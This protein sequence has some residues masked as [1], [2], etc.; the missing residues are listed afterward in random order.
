MICFSCAL[1]FLFSTAVHFLSAVSF[2]QLIARCKL[3]CA[4]ELKT[5]S[6]FYQDLHLIYWAITRLELLQAFFLSLANI[7]N[8]SILFVPFFLC[9]RKLVL[10]Q[11][12]QT[13]LLRQLMGSRWIYGRMMSSQIFSPDQCKLSTLSFLFQEMQPETIQVTVFSKQVVLFSSISFSD[14]K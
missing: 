13:N 6:P 8:F 4:T 11:T 12:N 5:E 1:C 14:F 9:F 7:T 2:T 3:I 10:Y